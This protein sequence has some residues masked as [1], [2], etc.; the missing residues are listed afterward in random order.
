MKKKRTR[1]A[2]IR[3]T[4]DPNAVL[5]PVARKVGV[6]CRTDSA[7]N[8]GWLVPRSQTALIVSLRISFFRCIEPVAF[9][10]NAHLESIR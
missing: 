8:L 5:K 2:N 7:G 1:A 6:S 9:A 4:S 10:R 3:Q